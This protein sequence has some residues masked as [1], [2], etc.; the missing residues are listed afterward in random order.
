MLG[1]F[2]DYGKAPPEYFGAISSV[3]TNYAVHIQERIC[4]MRHGLPSKLKFLPT[5]SDIVEFGDAVLKS[6]RE[7]M[8]YAERFRGRAVEVDARKPFR[9]FPQLWAEFGNERMDERVK[10]L[11]SIKYPDGKGAFDVLDNACK[12]LVT[13]GRES[14]ANILGVSLSEQSHAT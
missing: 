2:P 8:S 13:R 4:D 3:L 10:V 14:A 7:A 5:I 12:A 11:A 6:E 9:P 1:C